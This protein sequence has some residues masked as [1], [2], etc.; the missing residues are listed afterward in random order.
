MPTTAFVCACLLPPMLFITMRMQLYIFG[1]GGEE[2][3]DW[4]NTIKQLIFQT[5]GRDDHCRHHHHQG[6][7]NIALID[8]RRA[9]YSSARAFK[10]RQLTEE[11]EDA[12]Q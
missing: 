9:Q 8:C 6:N 3:E 4:L 7:G 1:G 2:E 11:E 5:R 12:I 10:I